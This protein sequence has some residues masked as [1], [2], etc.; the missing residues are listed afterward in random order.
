MIRIYQALLA[1]GAVMGFMAWIAGGMEKNLEA[2]F[3]GILACIV[4]ISGLGV[5]EAV[6]SNTR[7]IID[8]AAKRSGAS[9]NERKAIAEKITHNAPAR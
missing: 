3:T 9:A 2:S 1:G 4:A 6:S 5:I 8:A 7:A